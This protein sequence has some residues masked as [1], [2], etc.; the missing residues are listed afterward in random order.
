MVA[1]I[2]TASWNESIL[3]VEAVRTNKKKPLP[4]MGLKSTGKW[5][6]VHFGMHP[7]PYSIF[8]ELQGRECERVKFSLETVNLLTDQLDSMR[9]G[10]KINAEVICPRLTG[11]QV[12]QILSHEQM[13]RLLNVD[14]L[15]RIAPEILSLL[16]PVHLDLIPSLTLR[17]IKASHV[18]HISSVVLANLVDKYIKDDQR[19]DDHH[20]CI[21]LTGQHFNAA[22]WARSPQLWTIFEPGCL[23][24]CQ[25]I[26]AK[27][28]M[29]NL[30]GGTLKD[31]PQRLQTVHRKSH[32]MNLFER[33]WRLEHIRWEEKFWQPVTPIKKPSIDRIIDHLTRIIENLPVN[34]QNKTWLPF[35]R[36]KLSLPKHP[37][38]I[39]S[40]H[41]ENILDTKIGKVKSVLLS[42]IY[43]RLDPDAKTMA[44]NYISTWLRGHYTTIYFV[45]LSLMQGDLR[46]LESVISSEKNSDELVSY[47]AESFLNQGL[48]QFGKKAFKAGLLIHKAIKAKLGD[49][50]ATEFAQQVSIRIKDFMAAAT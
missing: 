22:S 25:S 33:L 19:D 43:P 32:L 15:N 40:N 14:C 8:G 11:D 7:K 17:S 3:R 2:L 18:S 28:T 37:H 12:M 24:K 21:H 6:T 48:V 10:W 47:T 16:K 4:K 49:Q 26:K 9:D 5:S 50:S 1:L 29:L 41:L 30:I 20:W 36:N 44:C 45:R 23:A 35:L 46:L 42:N 27:I 34:D 38:T 13:S 31:R 39:T